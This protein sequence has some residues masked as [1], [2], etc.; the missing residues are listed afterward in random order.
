MKAAG[1][2]SKQI[3]ISASPERVFDA[4]TTATDFAAWWAP[5]PDRPPRE[6]SCGYPRRHPGPLVL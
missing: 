4:L 3:R 6:A 5:Q 2:Y 1:G